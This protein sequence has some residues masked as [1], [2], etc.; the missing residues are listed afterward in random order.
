MQLKSHTFP[1]LRKIL[2]VKRIIFLISPI[3]STIIAQRK[4]KKKKKGR[5]IKVG[6]LSILGSMSPCM[7]EIR[8]FEQTLSHVITC[9]KQS[10]LSHFSIS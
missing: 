9:R 4:K 7:K 6:F 5:K 3:F 1:L 2:L 8:D 10:C